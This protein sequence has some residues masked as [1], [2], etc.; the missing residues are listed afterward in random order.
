MALSTWAFFYVFEMKKK[1]SAN[2]KIMERL[3]SF[4]AAQ[5]ASVFEGGGRIPDKLINELLFSGLQSVYDGP[6]VNRISTIKQ[7]NGTIDEQL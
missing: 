1:Y 6:A 5:N 3:V 2:H 7:V 4:V